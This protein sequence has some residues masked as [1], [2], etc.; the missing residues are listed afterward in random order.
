MFSF[1]EFLD[2]H[3]DPLYVSVKPDENSKR[4][5]MAIQNQ[6]NVPNPCS[7]DK[8]HTTLIYSTKPCSWPRINHTKVFQGRFLDWHVFNTQD[9]KN[10]L[11][12]KVDSPQLEERHKELMAEM[13]ASYD[14]DKYIPHITLSYDIGDYDIS[15]LNKTLVTQIFFSDEKCEVLKQGYN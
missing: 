2:Q 9:N 12:L 8:F 13:G 4:M 3:K 10:C 7:P 15:Q 1:K 14:F 5:L 11:V 6:G